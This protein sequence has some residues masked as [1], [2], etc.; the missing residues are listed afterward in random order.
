M[1]DAVDVQWIYPP[2]WDIEE[3]PQDH[4]RFEVRLIG[5]SDGT[6]ETDVTKMDISQFRTNGSV[7][8]RTVIEC[9]EWHIFGITCLLEWDRAPQRKIVELNG[10]GVESSNKLDW[11]HG[12]GLVD[13]GE[14]GDGTGDIL[15]TTTNASSGDTY[16]ITIKGRLKDS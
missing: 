13:T 10:N 8:T 15:L 7:V 14:A 3:F 11:R 6:G 5:T 2:N 16:D 4:R 9:I 1:A 12:G